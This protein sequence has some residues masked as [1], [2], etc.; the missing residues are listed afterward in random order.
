MSTVKEKTRGTLGIVTSVGLHVLFFGGCLILDTANISST[1][2]ER[3]EVTEINQ[4]KNTT[5]MAKTKS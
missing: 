4:V 1:S 2:E 5:A 3:H